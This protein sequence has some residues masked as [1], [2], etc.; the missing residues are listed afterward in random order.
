MRITIINRIGKPAEKHLKDFKTRFPPYVL[1]N[2]K[3]YNGIV[4]EIDD[5][6]EDDFLD[7]LES[8]G[9]D[10]ETEKEDNPRGA[11]KLDKYSPRFPKMK[12]T[13]PKAVPVL[14]KATPKLH[15][16]IKN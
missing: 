1:T 2:D 8:A 12:P 16:S 15:F 13:Y 3:I 5:E 4:I 6:N 14:Q 11:P 10:H 7:A 9:F